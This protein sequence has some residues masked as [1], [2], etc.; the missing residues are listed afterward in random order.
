MKILQICNKTPYPPKDGGSLASWMLT[1]GLVSQGDTVHILTIN[2]QKHYVE[3]PQIPSHIKDKVSLN[4]VQTDTDIKLSGLI[5]NFLFSR[6]PYNIERFWCERFN[7]ELISIL[8]KNH[9]D[10]V[11]LEG[12]PLALY[13]ETI[14]QYFTGK[15]VM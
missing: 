3:N 9:F 7:N 6:L 1:K 11:L 5:H 12:L 10:M 15:L 2:T 4:S 14:R 8:N 13:I